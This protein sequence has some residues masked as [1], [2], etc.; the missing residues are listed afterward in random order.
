MRVSAKAS[1]GGK[2]SGANVYLEKNETVYQPQCDYY[3]NQNQR[4]VSAKYPAIT[5]NQGKY[6]FTNIPSGNY[7]L[8]ADFGNTL[9]EQFTE[10]F[11]LKNGSS[12]LQ[13]ISTPVQRL[14]RDKGRF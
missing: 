14:W 6:H 7:S 8:W 1:V 13:K 4:S 12:T 2:L 3:E 9:S 5:D 11:L 10:A